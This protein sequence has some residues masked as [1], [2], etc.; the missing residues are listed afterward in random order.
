MSRRTQQVS[1]QASTTA[2][3]IVSL[4]GHCIKRLSYSRKFEA[5]S[6]DRHQLEN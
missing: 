4:L 1:L 5:N 6:A 2:A 3:A